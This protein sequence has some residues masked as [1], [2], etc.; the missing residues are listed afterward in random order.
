MNN[1]EWYASTMTGAE[2][3][4]ARARLGLTQA[5]LAKLLRVAPNTVARWERGERAVPGPAI[6]AIQMLIAYR[7][8]RVAA[9]RSSTT[10]YGR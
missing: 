3:R 5:A 9:I 6:A 8:S 10:V 1:K 4:A 7:F 2:L